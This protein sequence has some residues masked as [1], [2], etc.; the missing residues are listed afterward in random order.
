MLGGLL[1]RFR[2][3]WRGT[4]ERMTLRWIIPAVLVA[5]VVLVLILVFAY[6]GGGGGGGGGG[7]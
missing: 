2:F 7:Y 4:I 6:G 3:D 5:A 1:R